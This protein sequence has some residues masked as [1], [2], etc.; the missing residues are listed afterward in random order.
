[1]R[2]DPDEVTRTLT[3]F[4]MSVDA[5]IFRAQRFRSHGEIRA[6]FAGSWQTPAEVVDSLIKPSGGAVQCT[7]ML[8][9]MIASMPCL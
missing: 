2:H 4:V 7:G 6:Y 9:G 1:M 3:M 5:P 8:Q